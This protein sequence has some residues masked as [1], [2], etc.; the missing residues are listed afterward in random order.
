MGCC[1]HMSIADQ[2][3]AA[4]MLKRAA[5]TVVAYGHHPRKRMRHARIT[6]QYFTKKTR[7]HLRQTAAFVVNKKKKNFNTYTFIST[8]PASWKIKNELQ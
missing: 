2:R 6:A 7:L 1:E 8:Q 5:Q 4:H 3:A